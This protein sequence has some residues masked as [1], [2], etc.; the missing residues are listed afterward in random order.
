MTENAPNFHNLPTLHIVLKQIAKENFYLE[1][2]STQ[3]CKVYVMLRIQ[4][5]PL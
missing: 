4:Q 5:R 3:L 1:G 2:A